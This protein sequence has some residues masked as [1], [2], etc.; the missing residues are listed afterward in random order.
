MN[1]DARIRDPTIPA[2]DERKKI[3]FYDTA[4]RRT[5]LN[6]KLK[7]DNLK[8]SEFFRM[9]ITGYLDCDP[10]ILSFVEEYK[11]EME[12]HNVAKRRKSKALR[13]KSEETKKNFSLDD[14]D[15]EDLFDI[16]AEEHP[17]L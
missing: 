8:Q 14:S 1:P 7:Y 12:I 13:K 6:I 4:K 9:M 10:H 15:I 3:M 2:P 5:D 11:E 17:D 16:I